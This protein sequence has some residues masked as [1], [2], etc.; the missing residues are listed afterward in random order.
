MFDCEL[1][2]AAQVMVFSN[3]INEMDD[4]KQEGV[5]LLPGKE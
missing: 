4:M 1:I 5:V 2:T 3:I